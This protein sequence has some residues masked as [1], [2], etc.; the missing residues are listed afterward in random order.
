MTDDHQSWRLGETGL[1]SR[2]ESTG[3]AHEKPPD[4][5]QRWYFDALSDDGRE[6]VR[7][8]FT[9]GPFEDRAVNFLF[10]QNGKRKFDIRRTFRNSETSQTCDLKTMWG[11]C[12]FAFASAEYGS[13]HSV[14]ISAETRRKM[15]LSASFEWLAIEYDV[16]DQSPSDGS[17]FGPHWNFAVPR[18]DV[19][20][21]IT[22]TDRSG[23]EQAVHHF[24]GTGCHEYSVDAELP[25]SGLRW[26]RA[27]G[28]E[29]TIV[30]KDLGRATT[31]AAI[32]TDGRTHLVRDAEFTAVAPPESRRLP[33][34][35]FLRF[36]ADMTAHIRP[37]EIICSGPDACVVICE[38]TVSIN[39]RESVCS[40]IAEY[41]PI[42]SFADRILTPLFAAL[43]VQ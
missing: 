28:S 27:H 11:D 23:N 9:D 41:P 4:A 1:V 33:R 3:A 15:S 22:L 17:K 25:Q 31:A 12:S 38:V 16:L 5:V 8:V 34:A 29:A 30:F 21:R 10:F 42:R 39:G 37:V 26:M 14:E 20:G 24:R 19:T 36:D 40:G 7:L 13:G 43:K 35:E 6:A 2:I 18:A 32:I